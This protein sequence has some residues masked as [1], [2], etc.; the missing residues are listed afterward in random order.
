MTVRK[1]ID[2]TAHQAMVSVA[3]V[4]RIGSAFCSHRKPSLP[5]RKTFRS[6]PRNHPEGEQSAFG[7]PRQRHHWSCR[8]DGTA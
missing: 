1:Y 7:E 6:Y 5:H 8:W 3:G 2:S 4:L